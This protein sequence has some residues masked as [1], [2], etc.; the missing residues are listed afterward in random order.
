MRMPAAQTKR[1]ETEIRNLVGVYDRIRAFAGSAR[2]SSKDALRIFATNHARQSNGCWSPNA[3]ARYTDSL[4]HI[5]SEIR[6]LATAYSERGQVH[7]R[8]RVAAQGLYEEVR[9]HRERFTIERERAKSI[10][11]NGDSIL[12]KEHARLALNE[13][14]LELISALSDLNSAAA[15]IAATTGTGSRC[16]KHAENLLAAHQ[17]VQH[18]DSALTYLVSGS[19]TE[20]QVREIEKYRALA[21]ASEIAIY[22]D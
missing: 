3:T 5:R 17:S 2:T 7:S 22:R 4:D 8:L 6:P 13:A 11:A 15:R 1:F 19:V 20:Q 21:A 14:A 9:A 16:D 18:V 10:L 12:A